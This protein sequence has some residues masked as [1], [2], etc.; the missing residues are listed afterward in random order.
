MKKRSY[1]K[2]HKN[3][4]HRTSKWS[5]PKP[6]CSLLKAG[7]I[8]KSVNDSKRRDKSLASGENV[9]LKN[10]WPACKIVQ[11][12]AGRVVFPPK[13]I[14]EVKALAC[15]LPCERNLPFSRL[16]SADIAR[17]AIENGIV[18]SISGTTVWRWLSADAI[19][20]WQYRSWIFPRDPDFAQKASRVLDLYQGIWNGKRLRPNDYVISAD[21]KTS[22]QARDRNGLHTAPASGRS[23]RIEFEYQRAGAL[24]YIAAWDVRRAKIFGLCAKSTG[25]EVYHRL[26]DLV[27]KQEPYRSANRVFWIADNGSSH[28]GQTSVDRLA[29]WYP[30][31]I[32]IHTPVHASWLN[33]IEIYFSILQRKLLTPNDFTNI[34]TLEHHLLAFQDHYEKIAKPFKWKFTKKD[35]NR[36]LLKLSSDNTRREKMAA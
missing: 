32:Q 18:A 8:K 12:A 3:I 19:K 1:R 17:E 11:D 6:F 35:L 31:A 30:N 25:I 29:K 22:I 4:R 5:V 21:E 33:Q 10:A 7:K 9:S 28:R 20:P 13:V 34:E 16:S 27:M 36:I 24:A 14:M 2:C 15:Q 26:V 23:Q